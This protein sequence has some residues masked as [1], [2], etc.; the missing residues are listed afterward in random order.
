M[1]HRWVTMMSELAEARVSDNAARRPALC[2]ITIRQGPTSH[3]TLGARLG[4]ASRV[5]VA[6]GPQ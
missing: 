2:G 1:Q 4:G 5:A 6:V 3:P